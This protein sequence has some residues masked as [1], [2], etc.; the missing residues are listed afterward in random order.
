[1]LGMTKKNII[2]LGFI[3]L[4]FLLQYLLISSDYDLHRDEFLHLDQAHHLA[5]GYL[6]VPPFTSW[7]SY[8][9]YILGNSVFWVKFFPALFGA[10]TIVVV[11]KATEELNGNLFALILSATCVLFSTLLRLDALFQPNS[12]DV[13]SWTTFYLILIK[14]FKTENTKWLYV[15]ALVFSIGFLNKYNIV[16]LVIGFLPAI[17]LTKFRHIFAKKEFYVAL[18][19]GLLLILPNLI[20]QYKNNFPVIH[21]LNELTDTQLANVDRLDFL[22]FQLLFFAA[23][24][25]VIFSAFYALLFYKPFKNYRAFFGAIIF[26]LIIFVCFRAK[27]Y[28][29]IGLYPIYISFGSVFLGNILKDGWVKYLKLI[30]VVLPILFFV[31]MN[32]VLFPNKTPEYILENHQKYH[33]LGM[34]RWEDGKDHQLPQDFADMLGWKELAAKVD[35]ICAELPNPDNTFIL[36]DNY[37]QA[38][39][40]NYYSKNKKIVAH[41]FHADYINWL[42]FDK[43]IID[44]ILVKEPGDRDKNREKEVPIFDTVYLAGKRINR[45]AREDTISIYLLK[46]AKT[47][48]NKIIKTE[49]DRIKLR[50][51]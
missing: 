13:L 28:Y 29:A 48:I 32:N 42:P 51:N 8:L 10:L 36:C 15:G 33:R 26:T 37:G 19:L 17:L 39:A 4:K 6:S 49:T 43:K 2:L 3:I 20:W 25:L 5:W 23:A 1:M 47:D 34:L 38:G 16:F 50:Q 45:Y 7:I 35:S 27:N 14:Y 22:K 30:L 40:I 44:A 11:W 18:L 31:R 24:L 21:H 41:S 12:F 9:I 46:G